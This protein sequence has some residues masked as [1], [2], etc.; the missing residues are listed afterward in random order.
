MKSELKGGGQVK[1]RGGGA[2]SNELNRWLTR[3]KALILFNY[4]VTSKSGTESIELMPELSM[5]LLVL[6]LMMDSIFIILLN[7]SIKKLLK[8]IIL[9]INN[10]NIRN[11]IK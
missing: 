5:K 10:N 8:K 11:H 2:I 3:V 6:F 9:L 4:S 7:D 1:A